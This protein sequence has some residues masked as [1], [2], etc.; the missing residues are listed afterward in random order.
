MNKNSL[1]AAILYSGF[2][3]EKGHIYRLK[4]NIFY[5]KVLSKELKL[6]S[7]IITRMKDPRL[8]EEDFNLLNE[9]INLCNKNNKIKR[10]H[11]VGY[12]L[13]RELKLINYKSLI[14]GSKNPKD[15][16]II[17]LLEVLIA[18]SN[19]ILNEQGILIPGKKLF[20]YIRALHNL[21]RYFF[22]SQLGKDLSSKTNLDLTLEYTFSNLDEINKKKYSK[23][24]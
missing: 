8:N 17:E 13:V 2:V 19:N 5:K 11:I 14:E 23:Y 10:N 3:S 7:D 20:V 4:W 16:I 15:K 1:Y 24:F 21:P 6:W 9:F 18:D 22:N 12:E